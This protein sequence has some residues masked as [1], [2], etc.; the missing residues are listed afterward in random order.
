MQTY[1][2]HEPRVA[3]EDIEER[4]GKLVFLK[5][6]FS[7][8]A[9]LAPG[10]WLLFNGL[11]RGLL[12]YV[13]LSVGLVVGLGLLGVNEQVIAW[14]GLVINLIFGFEARDI[15]RASLE[16]RGYVLKGV[17]SGRNLPETER[18]FLEEWLPEAQS[19]RARMTAMAA[20]GAPIGGDPARSQGI[21]VIGMFPS[22][23][24]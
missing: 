24:G 2:V 16:R 22:H 3:P 23:G 15:Y 19:D 8:W 1:T 21:P 20:T 6:G 17:V 12:V 9:F 11:W 14:G 13:L 5:E 18:R 10:L 7:I 4:A